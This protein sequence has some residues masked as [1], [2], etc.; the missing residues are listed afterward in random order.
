M[1]DMRGKPNT[2]ETA[3]EGVAKI[4]NALTRDGLID[5]DDLYIKPVPIDRKTIVFFVFINSPY[6]ADPV[7]FEVTL[8]L[9]A[10]VSIRG[11]S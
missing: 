2:V 11:I 5:T 8:S 10:G 4:Q 1:E 3:R 7:G 9:D 6:N